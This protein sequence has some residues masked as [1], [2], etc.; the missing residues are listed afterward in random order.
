MEAKAQSQGEMDRN[1]EM[2]W[3]DMNK[4]AEEQ[5]PVFHPPPSVETLNNKQAERALQ[6]P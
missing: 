3:S 5:A 2:G 4:M 6:E 1:G